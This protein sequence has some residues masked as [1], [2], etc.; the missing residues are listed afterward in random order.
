MPAA[1]ATTRLLIILAFG[2][3][4]LIWGSTFL[5][6]AWAVETIPP[7]LMMGLR[8]SVAGLTIFVYGLQR[9]G[10][11]MPTGQQWFWG[12]VAGIL[13][14]LV[15]YGA[16]SWAEQ[17]VPS[18]VASVVM[19]TTPIWLVLFDGRQRSQLLTSKTLAAGIGAGLVGV[20]LIYWSSRQAVSGVG[21]TGSRYVQGMAALLI[22]SVSW[23]VGT[24]LY[25]DRNT[26]V[27]VPTR[28]GMQMLVGGS[29]LL[30]VSGLAGEWRTFSVG[31]VSTTSWLSLVYLITLGTLVAHT[32]YL[33][34]LQVQPPAL[35]GTYAYVN[36]VIALLL[37]WWLDDEPLTLVIGLATLI[38]LG[39]VIL[40][41]RA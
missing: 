36:P 30:V 25:R 35:V 28:M 2:A 1:P 21:V 37:G 24:L 33:W 26:E 6:I 8:F 17:Y 5:A 31:H 41:R 40:I 11:A 39:A 23:A 16:L 7:F 12:A 19:A 13:M 15:D 14:I 9:S 18:G 38:I 27:N 32:A 22:A 34:L 4:Y 29:L 3:I 20:W 10:K